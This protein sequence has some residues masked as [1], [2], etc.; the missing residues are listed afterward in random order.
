[1]RKVKIRKKE[2]DSEKTDFQ[3]KIKPANKNPSISNKF[4]Q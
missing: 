3:L 4:I 1:M 2:G